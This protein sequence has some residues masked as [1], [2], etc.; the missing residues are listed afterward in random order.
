M[1][2]GGLAKCN[3]IRDQ[4]ELK[5]RGQTRERC[6]SFDTLERYGYI[7]SGARDARLVAAG[8]GVMEPGRGD[9]AVGIRTLQL[10]RNPHADLRGYVALFPRC[11]RGNGHRLEG[12]VHLG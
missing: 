3:A 8:D 2:P 7:E 11:G 12:D 9:G 5:E 10:R 1:S 4:L 6:D